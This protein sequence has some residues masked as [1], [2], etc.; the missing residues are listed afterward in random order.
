ML[1]LKIKQGI[2]ALLN[3]KKLHCFSLKN[4]SKNVINISLNNQ[5]NVLA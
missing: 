1:L 2:S 3:A 5:L 4:Y